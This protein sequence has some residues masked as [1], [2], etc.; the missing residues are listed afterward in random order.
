MSYWINLIFK[1]QRNCEFLKE[2]ASV[3][4]LLCVFNKHW[5]NV[6]CDRYN[7]KYYK[8]NIELIR[9]I[10][11]AGKKKTNVRLVLHEWKWKNKILKFEINLISICKII[12]FC[13]SFFISSKNIDK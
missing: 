10:K 5:T 2:I 4:E 1:S 12:F 8:K 13:P 9:I 3:I 7:K 6:Y 11:Y